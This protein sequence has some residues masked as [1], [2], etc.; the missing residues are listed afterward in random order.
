MAQRKFVQDDADPVQKIH[1]GLA[2]HVAT[3]A[4]VIEAVE[5]GL[6]EIDACQT[7]SFDLVAAD[8]RRTLRGDA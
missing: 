2:N 8:L 4:A 3:E 6:A 5:V 1:L 7:V